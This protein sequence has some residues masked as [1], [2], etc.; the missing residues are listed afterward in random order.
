MV[1]SGCFVNWPSQT[2]SKS[3]S[4]PWGEV[5]NHLVGV[6]LSIRSAS[7]FPSPRTWRALREISYF[8]AHY[9]RLHPQLCSGRNA[10][11]PIDVVHCGAV[12]GP[13]QHVLSLYVGPEVLEEQKYMSDLRQR[14]HFTY[15]SPQASSS[16]PC[17]RRICEHHDIRRHTS[18]RGSL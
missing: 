12:V 5:A 14:P 11:L 15:C 3:A 1:G 6:C 13:H 16:P 17:Q 10:G 4:P 2:G 7:L 8:E 9:H 18:Q